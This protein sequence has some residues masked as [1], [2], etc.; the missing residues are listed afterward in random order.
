[1]LWSD[2]LPPLV[3]DVAGTGLLI[4]VIVPTFHNTF[5]ELIVER[6]VLDVKSLTDVNRFVTYRIIG[7]TDWLID[8]KT[9]SSSGFK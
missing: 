2:S 6:R 3:I 5:K 1:M 8:H 7:E 9:T 4:G